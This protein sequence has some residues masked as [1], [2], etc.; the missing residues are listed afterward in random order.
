[1]GD[2]ILRFAHLTFETADGIDSDSKLGALPSVVRNGEAIEVLLLRQGLPQRLRLTPRLGWGGRG[3]L[4][5]HLT[6]T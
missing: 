1:M 3:L 5:C 4:G 6:P 2:Q